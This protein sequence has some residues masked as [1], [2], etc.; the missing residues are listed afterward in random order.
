MIV[1]NIKYSDPGNHSPPRPYE[2][3][4]DTIVLAREL[5]LP[6]LLPAPFWLA[7][8]RFDL[9]RNTNSLSEADR[10]AI[11][12]AVEPV[13]VAHAN[14]LFGWLDEGTVVSPDCTHPAACNKKKSKHSL[15]RWKPP[16]LTLYFSW[17]SDAAKG[18]CDS[19]VAVG[20]K[21]HSEG[22]KRLW[23]EL[24]SFSVCPP[25]KIYYPTIKVGFHR[26]LFIVYVFN[27]LSFRS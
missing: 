22:A 12:Q 11:I 10:T 16:G 25:G 6:S 8:T 24:P 4:M 3:V 17:Q 5:D 19:C 2:F 20:R 18:L 7:A 23:E 15:K 14:Y 9:L 21:H 27:M 1:H 13:R 26:T